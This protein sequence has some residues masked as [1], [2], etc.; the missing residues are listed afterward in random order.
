MYILDRRDSMQNKE[1]D[2]EG[3]SIDPTRTE[4][5]TGKKKNSDPSLLH[6][7]YVLTI[8]LRYKSRYNAS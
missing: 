5:S 6:D 1:D 2:D 8:L 7:V 3:M 4:Y